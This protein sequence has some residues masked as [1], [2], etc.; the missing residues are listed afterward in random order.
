MKQSTPKYFCFIAPDPPMPPLG[1]GTRTYQLA[2]AVAAIYPTNLLVLFPLDKRL[3]PED[4]GSICK[5]IQVSDIPF[6]SHNSQRALWLQWIQLLL[7]WKTSLATAARQ[8]QYYIS[9][10]QQW[11]SWKVKPFFHIFT[12]LLYVRVRLGS[13]YSY[14]PPVRTLERLSQYKK[15]E[16]LIAKGV[17]EADV[18]WVDFS[19]LFP[20]LPVDAWKKS[21]KKIVCNAHNLEY[22]L[23][24]QFAAQSKGMARR[25]YIFQA[26]LMK[27]AE[28]KGWANCDL[29]FT[30][31][32]D[33]QEQLLQQLPNACVDVAPNGVDLSYFTPQPHLSD[34]PNLLFAG[35]MNYLPNREAANWFVENVWPSLLHNIP[36][37]TFTLA[38]AEAAQSLLH[39]ECIEGIELANNPPDMRSLYNTA[40]LVVVPLHSGS[41]TRLKIPEAL[42]MKKVVI[43]TPEGAEGITIS[44]DG[45]YLANTPDA[46]VQQIIYWI[47]KIRENPRNAVSDAQLH[48]YSWEVIGKGVLENLKTL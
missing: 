17:K 21:G 26:R 4:L 46:F 34:K 42:A 16:C 8:L 7:P 10:Y 32:A 25:W 27:A 24:E 33:E 23:W 40:W 39:L 31:S 20:I 45:L 44:G 19:Y 15:M 3:I 38:G 36:G 11:N 22:R 12:L 14:L 6:T 29:V 47:Q 48:P 43:S 28:L 5:N 2:K 1:G 37:I 9:N 41:G 35:S 13:L 18:I 30:C